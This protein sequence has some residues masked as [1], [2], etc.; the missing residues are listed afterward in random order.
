MGLVCGVIP[1]SLL[2]STLPTRLSAGCFCV[3][4]FLFWRLGVFAQCQGGAGLLSRIVSRAGIIGVGV[5]AVVSGYGSVL[6][7]MQLFFKAKP[8]ISTTESLQ[9]YRHR[10]QQASAQLNARREQAQSSK[11]QEQ[12]GWLMKRVNWFTGAGGEEELADL[13]LA[14]DAMS[15]EYDRLKNEQVIRRIKRRR[16]VID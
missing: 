2:Q 5:M 14:V 9:E 10:L 1:Y 11:S 6:T 7:P 8:V 3:Y 13:E 15:D 16:L 4:L 12:A